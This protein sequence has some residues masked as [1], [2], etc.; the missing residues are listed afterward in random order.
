MVDG[1][2]TFSVCGVSASL[3][4]WVR[5]TAGVSVKCVDGVVR[6]KWWSAIPLYCYSL[7]PEA[8]KCAAAAAMQEQGF[9]AILGPAAC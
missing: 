4:L 2:F 7:V 9:F 6:W 5:L 8:V 3:L 1:V